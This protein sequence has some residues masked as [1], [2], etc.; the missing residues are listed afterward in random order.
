MIIENGKYYLY[1]HIRLDTN[2]PFYIGI[3]TK[4][5]D[6]A[7]YETE[8]RRAFSIKRRNVYWNRIINKTDYEVEIILESN[9][10]EL[11]KKKEIEFIALYGRINKKGILSNITLGG[12]GT[13]GFSRTPEVNKIIADKHRGRNNKKSLYCYQ[14]TLNKELVEIHDSFNIAANK[15]GLLKQ[16]ILAAKDRNGTCGGFIWKTEEFTHTI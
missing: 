3:G 13:H 10:V 4:S 9:N 12:D 5:K 7:S 14:Y 8:Y 11:I 2:K 15:A 16:N 1:R 6:F